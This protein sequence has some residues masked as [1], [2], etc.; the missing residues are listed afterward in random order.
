MHLAYWMVSPCWI[1]PYLVDNALWIS[2][3]SHVHLI[4]LPII[5]AG[6]ISHVVH[7][8]VATLVFQHAKTHINY[9]DK[10]KMSAE[11]V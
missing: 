10:G 2:E 11:D 9:V 8:A 1:H 7:R 5:K 6:S 3:P 4:P